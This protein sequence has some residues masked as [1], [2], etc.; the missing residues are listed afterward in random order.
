M[1]D[2]FKYSYLLPH[3]VLVDIDKRIGD[4][5][6]SGGNIEDGYIKQQFRYAE[7]VIKEVQKCIKKR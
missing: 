3:V 5:L 4:W 2:L 7:K 1:E 6:V